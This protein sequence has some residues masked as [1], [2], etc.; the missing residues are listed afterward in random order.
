M[1]RG[2]GEESSGGHAVCWAHDTWLHCPVEG[3]CAR[4][5]VSQGIGYGGDQEKGGRSLAMGMR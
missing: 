1:I 3:G 4:S 2:S 5:K